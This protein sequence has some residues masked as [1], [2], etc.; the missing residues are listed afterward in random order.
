MITDLTI[1]G[2]AKSIE[3]IAYEISEDEYNQGVLYFELRMSPQL[4]ANTVR[5][6]DDYRVLSPNDPNACSPEQTV[7][8]V[9][10]GLKRGQKDFGIRSSLILCCIVGH[11][12]TS[13]TKC[14]LV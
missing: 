1:R 8:S 7:Q 2:D 9:L 13:I 11:S 10:N 4:S 14:L 5:I 12:G 3:R 6:N